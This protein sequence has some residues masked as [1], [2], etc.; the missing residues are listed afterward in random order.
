MLDLVFHSSS[1]AKKTGSLTQAVSC[2]RGG[3]ICKISTLEP[4][5]D[6]KKA[7]RATCVASRTPRPPLA[8]GRVAWFQAAS[9]NEMFRT[10]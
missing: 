1:A 9:V 3:K 2:R 10:D 7:G 8:T 5:T 6:A 4:A